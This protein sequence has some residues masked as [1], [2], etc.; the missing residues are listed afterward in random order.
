MSKRVSIKDIAA[1]AGVSHSTVSRALHDRGRMRASTRDRIL[2]LAEEMGYAPDAQARSLVMGR[3]H[4][5]G[6]VVTTIADP[7]VSDIVAGIEQAALDAGYSVFLSSSHSNPERELTVVNTFRQR[8]VDAIIVTASRLGELYSTYLDDIH[9]PV[10]LINN[11]GEGDYIHSVAS[12]EIG[13]ARQAVQY[14]LKLG[15]TRIGYIGS[16]RRP[17]SSQR[18]FQGYCQALR[19][20]H[21]VPDSDL[22]TT[23]SASNDI[24]A[25]KVGFAQLIKMLPS[26]ILTYNDMTAIGV[27][28]AARQR[29]VDI[30]SQLS[31]VGF[32]DVFL[33]EFVTPPLTSVRQPREAM[34]YAAMEMILQLIDGKETK[35]RIFP[36][37]LI[38]RQTARPWD[39]E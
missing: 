5:I 4:T 13:G 16:E 26:A 10:V 30:P 15:H 34:G 24:E 38:I 9:V 8:R 12:D 37:E 18:R 36:C 32:D 33:T 27:M 1:A 29:N 7:F 3:T 25:G 19:A 31:L 35:D 17:Y 11:Q 23:P 14:L 21:L 6:V 2:K 20:A 39:K 22:I 28:M